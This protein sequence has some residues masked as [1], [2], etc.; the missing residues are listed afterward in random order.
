[1]PVHLVK[2]VNGVPEVQLPSYLEKVNFRSLQL[3]CDYTNKFIQ[4]TVSLIYSLT[5]LGDGT[6]FLKI[7]VQEREKFRAE[8]NTINILF[9]GNLAEQCAKIVRQG[10]T[11]VVTGFVLE[12]SSS[13][14][15]HKNCL[16]LKMPSNESTAYVYAKYDTVSS[17]EPVCLSVTPKYTYTPLNLLKHGSIVNVYG[18][19][20]FFKPPY[21]SRGTDYCS[22]VLIMD[23]SNA[24]LTCMLFS[25]NLDS[26]PVIYKIGDIVRFH[27]LKIQQYKNEI[28][29]VTTVGFS[30]LTFEGTLGTPVIPR[31]SSKIYTFTAD[32]QK[33]VEALR[34]WAAN[35]ISSSGALIKLSNIQAMQFFD[36]TCQLVGKAEV[37]GSSFLLKVWDGTKPPFPSWKVLFE[38]GTLEGDVGRINQLQNLTVDI[39]VYDNHVSLAKSLKVGTFI[40]IYSLHTKIQPVTSK[41]QSNIPH[42]EF[43][44][45][46]GTCYGRG[47]KVLPENNCDVEELKRF[48][49][50][51]DLTEHQQLEKICDLEV[52]VSNNFSSQG[53]VSPCDLE[54]C[55]QLSATVLT[56][57]QY[58]ETTPLSAILKCDAPQQYRIRAKLRNYEPQKLYQSVK[59]HCPKCHSLQEVPYESDLE[60][61]L[62]EV[63]TGHPDPK[64]QNTELYNSEVWITQNQQERKIVIHF[65]K[66]DGILQAPEETLIMI[67]GGTLSEIY[68]LSKK[69]KGVIP[70]KSSQE[71]LIIP[72]LTIPFLIQGKTWYY[73]CKQCS[74]L[75][76]IQNLNSLVKEASWTPI[77]IAQALGIVP[78]QYVFVMTFTLDDG[79]GTLKVY[80]MDCESFFQIPAS[81]ILNRDDLQKNMEMIMYMLCPPG[82]KIGEY[83]WL[84]CFIKSYN[85][86][87]EVEQEICYRIFDT[88]VVEDLI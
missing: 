30:S 76:T 39:L 55:Q 65:V 61:V 66:N 88:V 62:Q 48:L 23:Q 75:E 17:E 41:Q 83:P 84:E 79:T 2:E 73:G 56:D 33:T 16:Q 3:G 12:E 50:S 68:Q 14:S 18:A 44:L 1:M 63:A 7:M 70:V 27:R 31:T 8:V 34:I 53:F 54:R 77:C 20:K 51:V 42:L 67:E 52:D 82:K 40:R 37:D 78:L 11:I 43:H 57:H 24:K 74:K 45:H 5:H 21:Q 25:V 72:D 36:L 60:L 22:V 6:S 28:Q 4:G 80:L 81:E 15:E 58:L 59:L 19:V 64:L 26:L 71:D 86:R 87:N 46:G 69:F 49:D 29:G 85:V 10:D 9:L 13:S 38:D 47:I 32:D 35:H